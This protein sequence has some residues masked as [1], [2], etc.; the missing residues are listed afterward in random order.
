MLSDSKCCRSSEK[1]EILEA[2]GGKVGFLEELK[3]ELGLKDLS[4]RKEKEL[5][6]GMGYTLSKDKEVDVVKWIQIT[7]EISKAIL[8]ILLMIN[9]Q[10]LSFLH[11]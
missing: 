8:M 10:C 3:L 11:N 6:I 1:G 9:L 5:I 7:E 4:G 2:K